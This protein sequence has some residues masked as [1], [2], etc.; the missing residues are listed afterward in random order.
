MAD[1]TIARHVATS[2]SATPNPAEREQYEAALRLTAYL[3]RHPVD[4]SAVL[5]AVWNGAIADINRI[6][7]SVH[8]FDRTCGD[9]AD[10][11]LTE[12]SRAEPKPAQAGALADRGIPNS[13]DDRRTHE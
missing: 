13:G 5:A 4:P 10:A 11:P 6:E 9:A 12:Q 1:N 3:D 2:R 7:V 8:R